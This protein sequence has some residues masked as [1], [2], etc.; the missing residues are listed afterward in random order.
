MHYERTVH[1]VIIQGQNRFVAVPAR[2]VS[3]GPEHEKNTGR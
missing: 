2:H 3:E 1:A